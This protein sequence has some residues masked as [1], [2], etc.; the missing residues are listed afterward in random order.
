MIKQ[1]KITR[2]SASKSPVKLAWEIYNRNP[3][4]QRK[5]AINLAISKGIA[6][7]T[8]RTQYQAWRTAGNNDKKAAEKSAKLMARFGLK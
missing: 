6:F 7:Y 2:V 1:N 8:A 4:L 3:K 5:D